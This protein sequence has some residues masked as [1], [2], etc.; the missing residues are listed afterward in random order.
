MVD[1]DTQED[2]DLATAIARGLPAH[3][4]YFVWSG[5]VQSSVPRIVFL[6]VDGTLTNGEISIDGDGRIQRTYST[7]D[8]LAISLVARKVPVVFLTAALE[9]LSISKRARMLGVEIVRFE[10]KH[11][12]SE[13]LEIC[14]SYGLSLDEALFVG[15]DSPDLDLLK[16][17][18]FAYVPSDS[19]LEVIAGTTKLSTPGGFGAVREALFLSGLLS[20][21]EIGFEG[22]ANL[23]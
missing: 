21:G 13:A 6:D 2:L 8:G 20:T 17:V 10:S 15:N 22:V 4:E 1:I 12:T 19:N 23:K 7:L 3:N 9:D 5:T 11:K 14:A 18:G 16:Q